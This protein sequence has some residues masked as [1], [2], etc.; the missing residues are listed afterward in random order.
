MGDTDRIVSLIGAARSGDMGSY[1]QLQ[2]LFPPASVA[3]TTGSHLVLTSSITDP[4]PSLVNAFT[5]CNDDI[6]VLKC[7]TDI[8]GAIMQVRDGTV[9]QLYAKYGPAKGRDTHKIRQALGQQIP[10]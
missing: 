7:P 2:A 5:A 4:P 3:P 1:K 10:K 6:K 8:H 9:G